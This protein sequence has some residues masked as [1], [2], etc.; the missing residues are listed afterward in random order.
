MTTVL[1]PLQDG[2]SGLKLVDR[3]EQDTLLKAA[4]SARISYKKTKEKADHRDAKLTRFLDS[5]GH[6]SPFRHTYFTF[7]VK[8]PLYVF[9][10]WI[11]YQVGSCWRQFEIGGSEIE[12]DIIDLIY[13][14]D[15]G[16]SWNEISGRYV[17]LEP[18][19]YI[20]DIFRTNKGVENKQASVP[21]CGNDFNHGMI[22]ANILKKY[23]EDYYF[24]KGLLNKGVCKEQARAVLPQSIYTEAYWTASLQAVMHFL[25]QRLKEDS[26]WEIRQYALGIK[27]LL[28]D[29]L[30]SLN[31]EI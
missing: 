8:C 18:E 20:P 26:Q 3:M 29:D 19:F 6:T 28:K 11:K 15:K 24:Y 27:E 22:K 14:T 23:H 1:C 21:I 12:V 30:E 13:D 7:H 9:R 25:G 4:N 10:Q 31:I 2:K 17:R 5:Q 16:C